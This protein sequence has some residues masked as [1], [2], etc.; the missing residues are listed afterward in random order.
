MNF[1]GGGGLQHLCQEAVP[2]LP[3]HVPDLHQ[4]NHLRGLSPVLLVKHVDCLL[5]QVLLGEGT[6]HPHLQVHPQSHADLQHLSSR[7]VQE[8][9]G[10]QFLPAE[11]QVKSNKLSLKGFFHS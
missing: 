7:I 5:L 8:R 6:G 9:P 3:L 10:A 1:S 2:P 11:P 4:K